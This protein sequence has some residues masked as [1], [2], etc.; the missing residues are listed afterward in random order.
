MQITYHIKKLEGREDYI[1][2]CPVMKPVS[3]YGKTHA[4]V[5]EKMKQA[6]GLYLKKHPEIIKDIPE[7]STIELKQQ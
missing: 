3:V 1:G 4:E 2:Y 7:T 6:L 5:Q